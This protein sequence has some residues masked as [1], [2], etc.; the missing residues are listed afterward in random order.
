MR[1]LILDTETTGIASTDEVLELAY[2]TIDNNFIT[3]QTF[4]AKYR[5]S[6]PINPHA[7]AVHGIEFKDLLSYPLSRT[8]DLGQEK[9]DFIIGH[10]ISFDKRMLIQSN[11][12]LESILEEAK[13]IDTMALA[14]LITKSTGVKF[15]N[16]KLDTLVEH[17]YPTAS[18]GLIELQNNSKYHDALTDCRKVNIVLN[19]VRN[20]FPALTTVESMYEFLESVAPKNKTKKEG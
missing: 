17:Y 18:S 4:V 13:Y 3:Q 12:G 6:V 16:N 14:K 20:V 2:I 8:I 7:Q 15:L 9:I 1:I 11:K 19:A 5:P 10:N